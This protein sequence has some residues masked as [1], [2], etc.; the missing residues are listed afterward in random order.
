[1]SFFLKWGT[2]ALT[3]A[4]LFGCGNEGPFG[5]TPGPKKPTWS[6]SPAG[7]Q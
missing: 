1:M 6:Y 5:N 7:F 4:L 3:A 2:L